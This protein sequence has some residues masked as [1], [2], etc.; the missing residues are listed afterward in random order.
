MSALDGPFLGISPKLYRHFAI[1]TIAISGVIAMFAD[2]DRRQAIADDIHQR[3]QQAEL[4]KIDRDKFGPQQI[5]M[6]PPP[7]VSSDDGAASYGSPSDLGGTNERTSTF[8]TARRGLMDVE[9][10]VD[11]KLLAQMTP[12]QRAAYLK[13]LEQ[14]RQRRMSEGPVVPSQSQVDN[15][16]AASARRSGSD[17]A[18]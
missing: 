14:E 7:I 6:P 12:Q 5:G 10:S 1:I 2:G 18:D 11:P 8:G 4:K 15:L 3:Q 17:S 13:K 9:I 16:I